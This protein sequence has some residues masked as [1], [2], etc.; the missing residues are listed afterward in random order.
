MLQ[1]LGPRITVAAAQNAGSLDERAEVEQI[2][3]DPRSRRRLSLCLFLTGANFLWR[4]VAISVLLLLISA[5]AYPQAGIFDVDPVIAVV[6]NRFKLNKKELAGVSPLI[7]QENF[8]VLGIYARFGGDDPEYS[9]LLWQRVIIGRIDFEDRVRANPDSRQKTALRAA[10]TALEDRVLN[11]VVDDFVFSLG[12]YL[13]LSVLE[14]EA[15]QNV[16]NSEYKRKHRLILRQLANPLTFNKGLETINVET[17][18]KLKMILS[19]EQFRDY[20]ALLEPVGL[21]DEAL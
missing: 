20:K 8:D 3:K 19:P 15:V 18:R 5:P 17:E 21:I 12:Q 13:D 14:I 2:V 10:R 11:L 4:S 1:N 7:K 6:K 16:L 9:E